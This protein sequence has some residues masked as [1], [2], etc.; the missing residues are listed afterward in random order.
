M[1]FKKSPK[2]KNLVEGYG[3]G[4]AIRSAL[5][6]NTPITSLPNNQC[7][8]TDP[9]TR[10]DANGYPCVP[11]GHC[12]SCNLNLTGECPQGSGFNTVPGV[13]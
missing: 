3:S 10:L 7:W 13:N 11:V 6:Y 9:G 4:L 5:K 8:C 2:Y 12:N 1:D